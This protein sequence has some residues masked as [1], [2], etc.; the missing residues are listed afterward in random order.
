[1]HY[2]STPKFLLLELAQSDLLAEE[3]SS[4]VQEVPEPRRVFR[5]PDFVC[6]P[7]YTSAF[8][9]LFFTPV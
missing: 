3:P 1:M 2:K 6:F 5:A 8:R 4:L 9:H 7:H